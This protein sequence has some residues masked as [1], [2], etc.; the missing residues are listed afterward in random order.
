MCLKEIVCLKSEGDYSKKEFDYIHC[1]C[2]V[3]PCHSQFVHSAWSFS[4]ILQGIHSWL[5]KLY[6]SEIC[7]YKGCDCQR[8]DLPLHL[9]LHV[10]VS[11]GVGEKS[12]L[13]IWEY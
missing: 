8:D 13:F 6:Y 12:M 5:Y 9:V 11:I 10:L 1:S 2:T 3:C 4:M 7:V